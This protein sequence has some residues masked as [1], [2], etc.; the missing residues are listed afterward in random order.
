MPPKA[1]RRMIDATNAGDSDAFVAAFAE[2]ADLED[3]GRVFHGRERVSSWNETDNI[4]RDAHFEVLA[5]RVEGNGHVVTLQVSG[6]GFNGVSDFYFEVAE[7]QI[8][9][10]VIRSG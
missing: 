2:D 10:M 6:G 4:G 1:V 9:S 5:E 7:D 8:T 3:W